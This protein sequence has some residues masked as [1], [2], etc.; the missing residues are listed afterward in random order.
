MVGGK[1][2]V[3]VG[4][5]VTNLNSVP[6]EIALLNSGL[7]EDAGNTCALSHLPRAAKFGKA[8]SLA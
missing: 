7:K 1:R 4:F 6:R 8:I 3:N 5:K 2:N